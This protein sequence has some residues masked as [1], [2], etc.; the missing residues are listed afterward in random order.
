MAYLFK[1][2]PF[3]LSSLHVAIGDI[4]ASATPSAKVAKYLDEAKPP[5]D[6]PFILY[7]DHSFPLLPNAF[8]RSRHRGSLFEASP[9]SDSSLWDYARDLTFFLSLYSDPRDEELTD[10]VFAHYSDYLGAQ[11][12]ELSESTI[13]RREYVARIFY[14]FIREQAGASVPATS[15]GTSRGRTYINFANTRVTT[16][17]KGSPTGRRRAPNL[18]HVLPPEELRRFFAAFQDRTLRAV[19]MS[20]YSTGARRMDICQ[21]TA[22]AIAKLRPSY[23]GGPAFIEVLS[24]GKKRRKLEIEH[25]LLKGLQ[26]FNVSPHRLKR[27]KLFASRKGVGPLDDNTPLFINRFGDAL[28]KAAITDAFRRASTRSGIIRT[29]HELRHEFAV[30]YLLSA[31]RGLERSVTR[32]GFDRWLGQ[33]MDGDENIVV[34][35]LSR[36]LG[37]AS[38]EFT[39][40]TYLVMLAETNPAVRDAWC[41]HLSS[42]DLVTL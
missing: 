38:P 18:L 40:S 6:C 19:A 42:I 30:N 9:L 4:L 24:K 29:P 3:D 15:N 8:L 7:E 34:V 2:Q 28:S 32:T 26:S 39:K 36:L 31:Y 35:R 5:P 41:E 23:P 1:Q 20:I 37:H 22:G 21:L 10:T 12:A 25:A 14:K 17:R 16:E 11:H 27:A 13:G 33:L